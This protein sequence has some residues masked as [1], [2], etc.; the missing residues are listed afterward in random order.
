MR[1]SNRSDR[2]RPGYVAVAPG[3]SV[4]AGAKPSIQKNHVDGPV[5]YMRTGE[6]H[7]LTL[8][9]RFL[10]WLGRTDAYRLERKY[11]PGL[12]L[13]FGDTPVADERAEP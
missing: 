2:P 12:D 8:W 7:W 13:L 5:L 11:R 1:Y 10:L 9:E 3:V 4:Q 6:L